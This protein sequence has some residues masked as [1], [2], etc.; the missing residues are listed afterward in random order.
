[1]QNSH[2]LLC[3]VKLNFF[4]RR[5]ILIRESGQL[6]MKAEWRE[7]YDDENKD[8]V[9]LK[10]VDVI[11]DDVVLIVDDDILNKDLGRQHLIIDNSRKVC[12]WSNVAFLAWYHQ[13][14]NATKK[15]SKVDPK[16]R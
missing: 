6:S 8:K 4:K 5:Q 12:P 2:S 7:N 14:K 3:L 11:V 15:C 1:M 9:L 13:T 10:V 16:M